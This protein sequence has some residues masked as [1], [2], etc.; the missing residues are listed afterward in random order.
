V[1]REEPKE[2]MGLFFVQRKR[3]KLRLI[4]DARAASTHFAEPEYAKLASPGSLAAIEHHESG[5]VGFSAGD[6]EVCFYQYELPE[7]LRGYFA[8]SSVKGQCLSVAC[9]GVS[10][11]KALYIDNFAVASVD[12]ARAEGAARVM[13]EA[14]A[15]RCVVSAVEVCS[16]GAAELLGCEL[17]RL[18]GRWR[19]RPERFWRLMGSL[20]YLLDAEGLEVTGRELERILGRTVA[21]CVLRRESLA[22]LS[23]RCTFAETSV[24]KR[25]PLAA[26]V[27]AE[28][29][30]ARS[31][32]PRVVGDAREKWSPTVAVCDASPWG[33]GVVEA[34]WALA[35]VVARGRLSERARFGGPLA[36][37]GAPRDRALEAEI[38][39]ARS[40]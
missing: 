31:L 1:T 29:D 28:L 13:Q 3:D 22:M 4:A 27:R 21:A 17:D 25:Q 39:R 23:A 10:D 40:C 12:G 32:L 16:R 14:L 24:Q 26:S 7:W 38:V 5:A 35:D 9:A 20:D 19:V 36:A 11:A 33:C 8:L 34:E 18:S 15:E 30:W 37:A 6:V 2:E